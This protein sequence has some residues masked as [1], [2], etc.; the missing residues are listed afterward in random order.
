MK[1]NI[2][3]YIKSFRLMVAFFTKIPIGVP[4]YTEG[5]FATGVQFLPAIGLIT[6]FVLYL[7][8]W[9]GLSFHYEVTALLLV[10]AYCF[11]TGGVHIDGLAGTC[12][13]IFSGREPKRVLEMMQDRKAGT[14]GILGIILV[15]G[16]Y[17]VFFQYIPFTA[18]ICMP[19]IGKSSMIVAAY[20]SQCARE[21]G[22]G[23][24]FIVCCGKKEIIIAIAFTI[25]LCF[26]IE[27]LY[28][29][30]AAAAFALSFVIK[31]KIHHRLGGF[32]GDILG[33][34]C[35]VAQVSYLLT[36]YIVYGIR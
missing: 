24:A 30:G 36:I 9:I 8:S 2:H 16:C 31:E 33:F 21:T 10:L 27:P 11:I 34:V 19:V 1:K 5:L 25:I 32:T 14:F 3:K 12:Q 20:K 28:L 29:L 35:E 26:L 4:D 18:L 13:G 6:G 7:V 17:Y 15:I 22:M 23:R